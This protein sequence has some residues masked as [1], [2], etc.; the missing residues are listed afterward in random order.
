MGRPEPLSCPTSLG[1]RR[2]VV[3]VSPTGTHPDS[4]KTVPPPP[5]IV[6]VLE[7]V[8]GASSPGKSP[9]FSRRAR[10]GLVLGVEPRVVGRDLPGWSRS[11]RHHQWET[12]SMR[13]DTHVRSQKS[14]SPSA[15]GRTS[16]YRDPFPRRLP[17]PRQRH[18]LGWVRGRWDVSGP[19]EVAVD[20]PRPSR[21]KVST[22]GRTE[23]SGDVPTEGWGRGLSLVRPRVPW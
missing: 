9:F 6:G 14:W 7:G 20:G 8:S 21:Y 4:L 23:R 12:K 3:R 2:R 1:A 15:P 18:D 13:D 5:S 10:T 22:E 17:R 16:R 11:F 19:G